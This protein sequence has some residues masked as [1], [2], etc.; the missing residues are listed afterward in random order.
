MKISTKGRYGIRALVDLIIIS[1]TQSVTLK[2]ISERQD[3]S[4][5]YLEQIFSMLRK[6]GIIIGRKGAQGGYVLSKNADEITIAD[7]L[8]A[9][10]GDIIIADINKEN[11]NEVERFLYD[12]LWNEINK[13]V[14]DYFNVITLYKIVEKY[15]SE[16]KEI[17]YYI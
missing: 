12:N 2:E 4:E 5:R 1:E 7:V 13:K 15:K 17:M 14:Y 3:I 6:A 16:N 11:S 8:I 10:E 9:L